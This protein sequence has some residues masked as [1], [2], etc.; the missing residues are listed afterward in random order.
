MNNENNPY[1]SAT[2]RT[3]RPER[4]MERTVRPEQDVMQQPMGAMAQQQRQQQAGGKACP[5]C[6]AVNDPEAMFC[7]H[8]QGHVS[9]LRRRDR[10]RC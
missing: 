6:G 10:P 4:T 9:A 1:T 7:A 5:F 2:Q 3:V 8:Q